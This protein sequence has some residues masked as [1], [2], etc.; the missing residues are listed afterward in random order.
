MKMQEKSYFFTIYS[1]EYLTILLI[2][3]KYKNKKSSPENIQKD[4]EKYRNK[5]D[6]LQ[7]VKDT[8]DRTVDRVKKIL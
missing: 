4:I 8:L 6:K 7:I 3:R 1:I 5:I 2:Y